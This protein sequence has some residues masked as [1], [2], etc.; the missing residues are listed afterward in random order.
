[1]GTFGPVCLFSALDR[2]IF[3]MISSLDCRINILFSLD[4]GSLTISFFCIRSV[5][6]M[7]YEKDRGDAAQKIFLSDRRSVISSLLKCI[8]VKSIA[9][10]K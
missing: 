2:I 4:K 3:L 9:L 8:S 10:S 1:M 6:P 7:C 5:N